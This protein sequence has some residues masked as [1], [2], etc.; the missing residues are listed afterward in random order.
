MPLVVN[1]VT[2]PENVANALMVNGVSI[3]QVIANG[4]LVWAKVV[5]TA[6]DTGVRYSQ[7]K[8][9]GNSYQD[10]SV[11]VPLPVPLS[12]PT[13]VNFTANEAHTTAMY[14]NTMGTN[15][16]INGIHINS[17]TGTVTLPAGTTAIN[18][19]FDTYNSYNTATTTDCPTPQASCRV[20]G[21]AA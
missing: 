4:T 20:W 1:G 2:I 10:T 17:G 16:T 14:E 8:G 21:T 11:S 18:I 6:F 12:A 15:I 5:A 7:L 3:T 9:G 19:F 13:V